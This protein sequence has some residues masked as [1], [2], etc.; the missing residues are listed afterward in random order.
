MYTRGSSRVHGTQQPLN[1][2]QI[3]F[4]LSQPESIFAMCRPRKINKKRNI[5]RGGTSKHMVLDCWRW[6]IL[7]FSPYLLPAPS[8]GSLIL[9]GK[10]N[11]EGT[12]RLPHTQE[13]SVTQSLMDA[14]I[15]GAHEGTEDVSPREK[16]RWCKGL[17][18]KQNR[19]QGA[20]HSSR[21]SQ[22]INNT[23]KKQVIDSMLECDYCYWGQGLLL[24]GRRDWVRN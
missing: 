4:L 15:C 1:K 10:H 23:H 12:Q 6:L 7:F 14:V 21:K 11:G 13:P 20:L 3:P 19:P 9:S 17:Y 18:Y 5:T 8:S 24:S 22:I 2:Y 16:G